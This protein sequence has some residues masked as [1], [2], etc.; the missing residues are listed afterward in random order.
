MFDL[1]VERKE[2]GIYE[3]GYK[4][5]DMQ[6]AFK[7]CDILEAINENNLQTTYEVLE[8]K[9]EDIEDTKIDDCEYDINTNRYINKNIKEKRADNNELQ[10]DKN[11]IINFGEETKTENKNKSIKTEDDPLS[12]NANGWSGELNED[13]Y[14]F[15]DE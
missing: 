10:A 7:I 2:N 4:T 9:E 12:K 11:G 13:G 15:D 6:E 8:K 14:M 5:K 1:H 3:V